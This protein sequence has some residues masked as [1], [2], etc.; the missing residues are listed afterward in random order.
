[1]ENN[2]VITGTEVLE[3]AKTA[4]T[5]KK[6]FETKYTFDPFEG[7]KDA[8]PKDLALYKACRKYLDTIEDAYKDFTK[9]ENV[10]KELL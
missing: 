8:D 4:Y 9:D 10:R 1:M 3:A 6:L 7:F 2:N 5:Y